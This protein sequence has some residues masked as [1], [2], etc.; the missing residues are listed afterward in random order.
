MLLSIHSQYFFD[1]L[2]RSTSRCCKTRTVASILVGYCMVW[3]SYIYR[4]TFLLSHMATW[5]LLPL[6]EGEFQPQAHSGTLP[7][8]QTEQPSQIRQ[9][10]GFFFPPKDFKIVSIK[11][12]QEL[13]VCRGKTCVKI[14]EVFLGGRE[15]EHTISI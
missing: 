12:L 3:K 2:L 1:H 5:K 7:E 4:V 6:E 15:G 10:F 11:T 9:F 14:G 13:G 8:S